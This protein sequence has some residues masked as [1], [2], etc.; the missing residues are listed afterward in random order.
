MR[1]LL[2]HL[3]TVLQYL[4]QSK[5]QSIFDS[6]SRSYT[7]NRLGIEGLVTFKNEQDFDPESYSV[8]LPGPKSSVKVTVFDRVRVK[9]RVEQDKNTLRGKVK[10]SLVSPIDSTGL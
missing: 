7:F 1:L 8:T 10:M 6:S 2:E 9:I 5:L 3:E 4:S